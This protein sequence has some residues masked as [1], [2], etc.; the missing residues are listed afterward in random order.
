M[1]ECVCG[2]FLLVTVNTNVINSGDKCVCVCVS[3]KDKIKL[4]I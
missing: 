2:I 3:P 4:L 1:S